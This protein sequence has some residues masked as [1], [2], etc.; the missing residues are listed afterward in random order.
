MRKVT[1][2]RRT[3]KTRTAIEKAFIELIQKNDINKITIK[4]ITDKADTN[5]S[6]FYTHYEDIYDLLHVIEQKLIDGI[7]VFN[8]EDILNKDAMD[9]MTQSLQYILDNRSLF[10][11]ISTSSQ[12]ADFLN[13][14][15]GV[16][17]E[18][19]FSLL[20]D[21]P[22]NEMLVC[23]YTNGAIAVIREWLLRE[24]RTMDAGELCN[25]LAHT[26]SNGIKANRQ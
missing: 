18:K 21:V 22:D 23:L 10:E 14:L 2:D 12:G 6:T 20:G 15:S 17:G 5:R 11:A 1:D 24:D 3:R 9:S 19:L 8:N 4:D 13:R 26:V 25:F 16:L 7:S